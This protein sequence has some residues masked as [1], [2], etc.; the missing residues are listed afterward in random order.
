MK[1]KK[2]QDLFHSFHT[3]MK[4]NQE[5]WMSEAGNCPMV[6]DIF[7]QGDSDNICLLDDTLALLLAHLFWG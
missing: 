1:K 2:E 7:C 6:S 3:L 4:I 5:P